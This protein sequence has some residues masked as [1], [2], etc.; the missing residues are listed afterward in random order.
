MLFLQIEPVSVNFLSF[1]KAPQCNL[2]VDKSYGDGF[3]QSGTHWNNTQGYVKALITLS[4]TINIGDLAC[5]DL[6]MNE[7]AV[8]VVFY[9]NDVRQKREY[10]VLADNPMTQQVEMSDVIEMKKD[11]MLTLNI[12]RPNGCNACTGYHIMFSIVPI[13]QSSN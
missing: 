1:H 9:L 4:V 7:Y 10:F 8:T 12:Y 5:E 11:D 13:T 2:A 3:Q 6:T